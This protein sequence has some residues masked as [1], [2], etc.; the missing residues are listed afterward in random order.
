VNSGTDAGLPTSRSEALGSAAKPLQVAIVGSGPAGFYA[1]EALLQSGLHVRVDMIERLPVPFGLVRYGVA[2]DHPK[3]KQT[4]LVFDKIAQAPEFAF[5][6]NVTVGRDIEVA[7]LQSSHHAIVFAC[8]AESDRRLGIA[9]EELPNSHTATQFVGW[10]NGHPDYRHHHFDLSNEVV[11]IVGQGNVTADVARILLKSVDEL[12]STDIAEHALDALSASRVREIHIIGRRGPAQMKFTTKELRELAEHDA[13]VPR[14]AAADLQLGAACLA[15]LASKHNTVAA[16]NVDLLNG[17]A[18]CAPTAAKK[19]LMFHFL[20][21]PISVE[22]GSRVEQLT[23]EHN[24]LTGD[25][26]SQASRGAGKFS[27]L[28]CGLLFRSIGYR[29][30]SLPGVPFDE[31]TAVFPNQ[32]GRIGDGVGLYAAGWIKRGPSGIIGTNRADAVETIA[33]LLQDL[34]ALDRAPKL[35]KQRL[36]AILAARGVRTVGYE[37]WQR[38][39][40]AEIERGAM[41]GKTREKFSSTAEMLAVLSKASDERRS[42]RA[43]TDM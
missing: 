33:S 11:A 39:D 37:E 18:A 2:P 34:P 16:K 5:I 43:S 42:D 28:P 9:G 6:G 22:G 26:F 14:V 31:S 1:A 29:G 27:Q 4:T 13:G 35:G 41:A 23:L 30:Q 38:I 12:K 32:Q 20:K 19:R 24:V 10:Y 3:L 25:A 40:R 7:E 21:T 17:W 15:E 36:V 8:G